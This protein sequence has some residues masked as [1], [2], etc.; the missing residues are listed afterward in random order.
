MAAERHR[1]RPSTLPAWPAAIFGSA[2]FDLAE[3][4][5]DR[6][7]AA[8]DRHLDLEPGAL[9]I[10][11][12]DEAVEGGERTIGDADLLADLEGH[13]GLRPLH[14]FLDLVE[15][16]FGLLVG[17]RHR[18]RITKETSDF[19]GILNQREHGIGEVGPDQNIAGEELALGVHLAAAAH[20]H[21]LLGR[22]DDL[23][24][25]VGQALL[26]GLVLDVLG[27]FLLEIGIGVDD[28]PPRSHLVCRL[29]LEYRTMPS[30]ISTAY[31]IS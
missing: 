3:T 29:L 6:H 10:D 7:G 23:L 24:D 27:H 4:Q 11:L 8:E 17:N 5:F 20:L 14:P 21:D 19:R 30:R 2:L 28:V 25:L 26:F 22:Y 16:L 31:A 15:D 13:R 9:L 12:L 1:R 18:L